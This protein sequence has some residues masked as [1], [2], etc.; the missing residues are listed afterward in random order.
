MT[1]CSIIHNIST[2]IKKKYRKTKDFI[3]NA[4]RRRT[5]RKTISRTGKQVFDFNSQSKYGL[6]KTRHRNKKI[7]E[8]DLRSDIRSDLQT[9]VR[10]DLASDLPSDVRSDLRSDLQSDLQ[11]DVRTSGRAQPPVGRS[12]PSDDVPD[13]LVLCREPYCVKNEILVENVSEDNC[14]NVNIVIEN[15]TDIEFDYEIINKD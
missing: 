15:S 6:D 7:I 1:C 5:R 13:A 12:Q 3:K 10:S 9:D 14:S 11:I 4:R 2:Y 8:S